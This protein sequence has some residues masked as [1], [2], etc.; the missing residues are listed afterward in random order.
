M[1][2]I[3][4]IGLVFYS[5]LMMHLFA[6]KKE[7]DTQEKSG[8]Y[9]LGLAL[10][11]SISEYDFT[12]DEIKD[13]VAGFSNGLSKKVDYK[14]SINYDKV[15]QLIKEKKE[16]LAKK[17]KARGEEYLKKLLSEKDA[18][19]LDS[20]IVYVKRQDGTGQMPTETDIV[21]VHYRGRLIDGTEFDS[22]YKKKE[23]VEFQLNTVIPCW[24]KALVKM[25]VGEKATIGCPSDVA[26]GDNGIERVIPPGST[27]IFDVELIDIV[28]KEKQAE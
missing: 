1:R 25:K 28:K 5:F 4:I 2:K 17:N 23:P 14:A 9:M 26:Y 18:M 21:K 6:Q 22:S 24:T 19:L 11:R 13:I 16:E 10:S 8:Y 27:L 3:V 20:D 15:N 7:V 12:A